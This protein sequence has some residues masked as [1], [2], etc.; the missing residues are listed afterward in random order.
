[1]LVKVARKFMAH[2]MT[3]SDTLLLASTTRDVLRHFYG[4]LR[5][6]L[7]PGFPRHSMCPTTLQFAI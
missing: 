5:V 7:A 3:M 2:F 1:M 4:L 6:S